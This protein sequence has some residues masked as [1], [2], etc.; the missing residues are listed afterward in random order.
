[1]RCLETELAQLRALV[2][3]TVLTVKEV[4]DR[5]G[6]SRSTLHRRIKAGQFPPP[7]PFPRRGWRLADLVAFESV[8][9]GQ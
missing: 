2:S 8:V 7:K 6:F 5:C 1:M 9:R 4:C 3:S